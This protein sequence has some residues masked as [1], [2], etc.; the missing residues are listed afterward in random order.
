MFNI[1]YAGNNLF[2]LVDVVAVILQL[3]LQHI[4]DVDVDRDVLLLTLPFCVGL[5]LFFL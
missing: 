4:R 2:S 1:T 3:L 5:L